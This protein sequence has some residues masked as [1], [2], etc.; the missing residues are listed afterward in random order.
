MGKSEI[1]T[2]LKQLRKTS[3]YQIEYVC[4]ELAKVGCVINKKTIY[5]Y[6]NAV[7]TPNADIFLE[8]CRI[9]HC[10]NP[11][12]ILSPNL[13]TSEEMKLVSDF[14]CLDDESKE[15]IKTVLKHELDMMDKIIAH[16]PVATT[17]STFAAHE[18]ENPSLD[19]EVFTEEELRE[20][21]RGLI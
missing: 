3:G 5:G 14:R 6:E 2:L 15:F 17:V 4:Q 21:D 12:D 11:L 18:N 20:R 7:S 9:Y 19:G 8:L 13:M 16:E 10:E 1:A